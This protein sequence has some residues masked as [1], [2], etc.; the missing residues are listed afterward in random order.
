[1]EAI[2]IKDFKNYQ[3][4]ESEIIQ[5]ILTGEKELYEILVRRNNQKLYR[6][7]RS[8]VKA[9]VEIEH[10]MQNIYLKSFSKLHQFKLESSF[11]TWLIRIGINESLT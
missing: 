9:E 4:E 2:I 7:I 11:A 1:M 10:I 6:V 5:R 3:L 8:Y